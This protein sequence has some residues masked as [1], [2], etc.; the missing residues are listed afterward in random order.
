MGFEAEYPFNPPPPPSAP[1]PDAGRVNANG[2][3]GVSGEK[4]DSGGG[5]EVRRCRLNR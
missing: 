3:A 4:A 1:S 5:N 2:A